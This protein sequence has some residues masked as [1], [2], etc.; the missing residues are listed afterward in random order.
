[1]KALLSPHFTRR[2]M[3]GSETAT[4]LEIDNTPPPTAEHNLARLCNDYLE[5]IRAWAGPL[6]ISSGYRCPELNRAIGG[7]VTS[8]HMDGR[9]ADFEPLSPELSLR[10]VVFWLVNESG[11][12]FDQVI[13]EFG[14]WV[15]IG[16]AQLGQKP[17]REALIIFHGG[18]Y[19]P[20]DPRDP[21]VK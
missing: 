10:R 8:A 3:T 6:R 7:S 15:H 16:I 13:Y 4:R 17:R 19:L 12:D 1:M 2:E 20:F 11:L 18:G 21:R 14:A 5:P 9:A